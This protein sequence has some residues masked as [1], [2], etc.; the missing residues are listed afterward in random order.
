MDEGRTCPF[1]GKVIQSDAAWCAYCGHA[2]SC[3]VQGQPSISVTHEPHAP[4]P[5]SP[6]VSNP[7]EWLAASMSRR[8]HTDKVIERRWLLMP[9]VG[10]TI[11]MAGILIMIFGVL[12]SM[13]VIEIGLI[14]L[15]FGVVITGGIMAQ[16]NFRMLER[17]DGHARRERVLRDGVLAY[18]Q[19][20]ATA[21]GAVQAIHPQLSVMTNLNA[22]SR[23]TERDQPMLKWTL[24]SYVPVLQL[25][26]LLRMTRF[27]SEHDRRWTVFMQQVQSGGASIGFRPSLPSWRASVPRPVSIYLVIS[28]VFLPF[29]TIWYADLIKDFEEHFRLQWQ[30]EDQMIAEM[31]WTEKIRDF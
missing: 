2:V 30:F 18:L 9:L 3:Q 27:T 7:K 13:R 14:V 16:L 17:Q 4:V 31:K 29:I 24:F 21:K 26:V 19:G 12:S 15:V 22:E 10:A 6:H 25:Y 8:G 20:Q 28:P 1:C 11:E 5:R 23:A